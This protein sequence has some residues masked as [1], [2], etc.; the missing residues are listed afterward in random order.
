MLAGLARG[1]ETIEKRDV[2]NEHVE[3]MNMT[4]ESRNWVKIA[5]FPAGDDE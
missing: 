3:L 2:V 4:T 1:F 5:L